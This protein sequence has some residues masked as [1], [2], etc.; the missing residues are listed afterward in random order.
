MKSVES[1]VEN[2]S[3]IWRGADS[4][5]Q[6]YMSLLHEGCSLVNPVNSG[7]REDL[8]AIMHSFLSVEPDVRVVPIRWVK[9]DDGVIIEWINT[10]T[11][12]G[13]PFELRGVDCFILKDGKASEGY[14]Y[15]DPRPFLQGPTAPSEQQG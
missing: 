3:K 5:V 8:P 1:F 4:D 15:F 6:L 11:L 13:V 2:W 14:S 9:T 10:G 12:H 7:T